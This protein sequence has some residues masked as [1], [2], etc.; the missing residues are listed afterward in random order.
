MNDPYY[1]KNYNPQFP[2][3]KDGV[4]HWMCLDCKVGLIEIEYQLQCPSV[5]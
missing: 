5:A 3:F 4:P 2:V 1:H